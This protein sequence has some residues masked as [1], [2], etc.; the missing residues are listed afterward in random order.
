MSNELLS[1]GRESTLIISN[2]KCDK[3]ATGL[4]HYNNLV[5]T[6]LHLSSEQHSTVDLLC[7]GGVQ[8]LTLCS[9]VREIKFI[10]GWDRICGI[11]RHFVKFQYQI[12]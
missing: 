3:D 5:F 1:H 2:S 7:R 8:G 12:H 6:L 10:Y 11:L 9:S 4:L